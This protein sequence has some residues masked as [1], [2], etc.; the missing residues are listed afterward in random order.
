MSGFSA[1]H[2]MTTA[3]RFSLPAASALRVGAGLL[4][5]AGLGLGSIAWA[6][7]G[8]PSTGSNDG[9]GPGSTGKLVEPG[10]GAGFHSPQSRFPPLKEREGVVP[11]RVLSAVTTRVEGPYVRPV[12]PKPV[13]D[14]HNQVVMIQGFM[15]PLDPG[16]TKQ[17]HFLLSA[18]PTT[19]NF[20]IP[21]GPEGLV[22][23]KTRTPVAFS[24]DAI[25]VQ[26]KLTV[27]QSD[28]YGL[29]YRLLDSKTVDIK[30]LK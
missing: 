28:P 22:E 20:C 23:V 8:K 26:G 7:S 25:M 4:L 13:Q 12:Y 21:A 16:S 9:T 17:K 3:L 19:C 30:S 27:L 14:L 1:A 11:W 18:V 10:Q 5:C 6:Q 2:T 15:M 29:Y 24:Q